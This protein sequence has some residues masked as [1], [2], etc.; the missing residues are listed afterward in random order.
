MVRVKSREFTVEA[1]GERRVVVVPKRLRFEDEANVDPVAV[2]DRVDLTGDPPRVQS[3]E[4][5]A[6][7]IGRPASGRRGRRQVFAANLDLAVI[8]LSARSPVWKP[9][10]LDRYLVLAS[11]SGIA[12]GVCLNK[13]D[14]D[15]SVREAPEL[16][17]YAELGIPIR[18]TS[19]P[20]GEGLEALGTLLAG[21][22]CVF[23]GPSG[24]GKSSLIGALTGHEAITGEVSERTG[25]GQHTTTWVEMIPIPG[26]GGVVDSPGLRVLDLTGVEAGEL[27][28]HFPELAARAS[29]CRFNDCGHREEPGCAVKAAVEAG[30]IAAHRYDSYLR[31]GR[32]LRSGLG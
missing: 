25:K 16:S 29:G 28:G 30:E 8:V 10:T 24:A 6:N 20:G 18:F 9:A 13:I 23:L 1:D 27:A 12:A 2:G 5:R 14:L 4:P 15:P 31:I 32:S 22:I 3:V 11:A 7:E 21:K 26:G 17:V 19:V